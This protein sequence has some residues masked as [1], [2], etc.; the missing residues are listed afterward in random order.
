MNIAVIPARAGSKRI[1][2]K[3]I[4]NFLG[5]PIISY[6]IK[7]AIKSKIF[8]DI[9]VST[10]SN[11]IKKIAENSGAKVYF[12][13]PMN[14]STGKVT[15]QSVIIHC[16]DWFK[17]KNILINNVCCIYPTA[18]FT[19]AN[20]LKK[21]FN[22]IKNKKWSFVIASQ[23]YSTQIERAFR[24]INNKVLL[25][26]KKKFLMNSQNFRD[27]YH[28]AG[29]FY[30]GTAK[31]WYAKNT[32]LNNNSTIYELKKYPSIDINTHDDWKLALRLYKFNKHF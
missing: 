31:S 4:K 6:V 2:N 23:K 14:L 32:I 27:F 21:S 19:Q 10:D 7:E 3:N 13:R 28:D 15:T 17:K 24:I 8:D 11:K 29:Q 30:W 20:D 9:I 5:N 16:L 1:K 26:D 12:K 25:V 18:I 22:L